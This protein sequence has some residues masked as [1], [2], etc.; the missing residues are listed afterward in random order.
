MARRSGFI[1]LMN[2]IAREQ[3]RAQRQA[4]TEHNRQIR[5]YNRHQKQ[6]V[7]DQKQYEKELRQQ[8]LEDRQQESDDLN[9]ELED[10]ISELESILMHTLKVNDNIAFD[11]LKIKDDFASFQ[12]PQHL[13]TNLP[14][15]QKSKFERHNPP[16]KVRFFERLFHGENGK[17]KRILTHLP[18]EKEVLDKTYQAA[19]NKWKTDEQKRIAALEKHKSEYDKTR[20]AFLAKMNQRNAEVDELEKAYREGDAEAITTYNIMVLERSQYPE[21]F[22]QEF[23]IA[24][25]PESKELIIDYELPTLNIIPAEAEY[26]FVKAKDE[27]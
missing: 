26:K 9:Q 2:Q 23:R 6:L 22:P 16:K 3:A 5:E 21:N 12:P 18:I 13:L 20:Q 25:S 8:Y 14:E 1:G 24:Y 17:N 10:K 4:I 7:R 19:L 15:P 27:I 11:S